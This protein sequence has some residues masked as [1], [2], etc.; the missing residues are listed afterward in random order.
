[1]KSE[2]KITGMSCEHC[3]AKVK[4]G[5]ESI[6]GVEKVKINLKKG[7]GKVKYDESSVT[8]QDICDKVAEVGYEAEV[9]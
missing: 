3:V 8:D 4:A 9:N 7:L 1:M 6:E 2:Y 5:I